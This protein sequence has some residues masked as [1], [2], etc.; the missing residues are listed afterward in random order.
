MFQIFCSQ[1]E[2]FK[3][4]NSILLEAKTFLTF[5][6]ST[7]FVEHVWYLKVLSVAL[8]VWILSL[9]YILV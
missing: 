4:V 5:L 2:V 1:T 3:T 6:N 8:Q 7:Q 9:L